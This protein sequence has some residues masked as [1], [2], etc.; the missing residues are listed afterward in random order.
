MALHIECVFSKSTFQS[1]SLSMWMQLAED[2]EV[3]VHVCVGVCFLFHNKAA[4]KWIY[5]RYIVALH[6]FIS[7]SVALLS[8]IDDVYTLLAKQKMINKN[9]H[10]LHVSFDMVVILNFPIHH[11]KSA[12]F[13]VMEVM[14]YG[15]GFSRNYWLSCWLKHQA[16]RRLTKLYSERFFRLWHLWWCYLVATGLAD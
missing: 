9:V 13:S 2:T 14:L 11:I 7:I 1:S 4:C 15:P 8:R 12:S 6:H 3:H 16:H 5:G 10:T